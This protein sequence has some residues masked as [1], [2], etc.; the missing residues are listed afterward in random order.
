MWPVPV[1]TLEA[2]FSEHDIIPLTCPDKEATGV[3]CGNSVV[4][5]GELCD[6][7]IPPCGDCEEP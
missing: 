7:A 1:S 3:I 6:I 5:E 4:D 2:M